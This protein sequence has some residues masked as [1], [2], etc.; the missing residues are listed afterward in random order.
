MLAFI[1]AVIERLETELSSNVLYAV[2]RQDMLDQTN[3]SIAIR[4]IPSPPGET[5]FE[6]STYQIQFQ[7]LTKSKDQKKAIQ[8]IERMS[9]TLD[10]LYNQGIVSLDDTFTFLSCEVYVQPA[11]VEKTVA[12]EYVYTALFRAE[13][14]MK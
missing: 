2:I 4:V 3:D 7:I 10:K 12:S 8:A 6:G 9:Y 13:I 5:Y 14:I 11:F 1:D